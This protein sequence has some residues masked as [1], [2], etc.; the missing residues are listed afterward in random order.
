MAVSLHC[1]GR[2]RSFF[3][4]GAMAGGG[5]GGES[6]SHHSFS[7]LHL[8]EN[9]A[10]VV[11]TVICLILFS[12]LFEKYAS[13]IHAR[14]GKIT[15]AVFNHILEE[16]STLGLVSFVLFAIGYW[17]RVTV[18]K[19]ALFYFEFLH[20]ELFATTVCYV[21]V[22]YLLGLERILHVK[23][24]RKFDEIILSSSSD[25]EDSSRI[26]S[27]NLLARI[28]RQQFRRYV[29]VRR[30]F[31]KYHVLERSFP[32]AEYQKLCLNLMFLQVIH[33][34]WRIGFAI[35]VW[36]IV[37]YIT[38]PVYL[39]KDS[40]HG[41]NLYLLWGAI[42]LAYIVALVG[43]FCSYKLHTLA[44]SLKHDGIISDPSQKK[45]QPRRSTELT[46]VS[47]YKEALVKKRTTKVKLCPLIY[48]KDP[49]RRQFP[50][51]IPNF[52]SRYIQFAMI[53][54]VLYLTLFG[55]FFKEIVYGAHVAVLAFSIGFIP[56]VYVLF[57]L[58]PGYLPLTSL[59]RFTGPLTKRK[60]LSKLIQQTPSMLKEHVQDSDELASDA[61]DEEHSDL[62]LEM[63]M[64]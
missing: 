11:L 38:L 43:A 53:Y 24:R 20:L 45:I 16:L 47:V 42:I 21:F 59:I 10:L 57:I 36:L 28:E 63:H 27:E 6:S 40:E 55:F 4:S 50:L 61:S 56:P 46:D 5:G 13:R 35:L 30:H 22:V 3:I 19:N 9:L 33:A 62:D 34:S 17:G 18:P 23:R 31:I 49:F 1:G 37:S 60:I 39:A 41:D 51:A 26:G 64:H 54:Q 25:E 58:A 2:C 15:K 7:E 44:S 32:F 48:E 8:A 12:W 29:A 14:G 52:F